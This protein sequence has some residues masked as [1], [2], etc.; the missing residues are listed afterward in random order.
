MKEIDKAIKRIKEIL[1][2]KN[3]IKELEKFMKEELS[4]PCFQQLQCINY[5]CEHLLPKDYEM[6]TITYCN[7]YK[8]GEKNVCEDRMYLEICK[9]KGE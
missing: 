5:N 7:K 4:H 3:N 2:D 1:K 8:A 9:P 6:G